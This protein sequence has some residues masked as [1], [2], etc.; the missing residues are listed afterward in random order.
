VPLDDSTSREL[1]AA[2]N[3]VRQWTDRRDDLV[4]AAHAAG[5][6]VREIARLVG[7]GHPSVLRIL[8]REK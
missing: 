6:G 1:R 4:R 5:G 2:G 8:K 3:K 7:L